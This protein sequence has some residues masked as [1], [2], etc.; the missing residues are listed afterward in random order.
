MTSIVERIREYMRRKAV[1]AKLRK[2]I[3]VL[4]CLVVFVTT[5]ALILPCLAMEKEAT[6]GK[7]VHEH[8]AD[9]YTRELVCG[10]EESEEH[11]HTD[12]CY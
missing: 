11:Q 6:C 3:S 10:Q 5:Y 2:A 12:D 1:R 8:T 9:C 4:C 7:E